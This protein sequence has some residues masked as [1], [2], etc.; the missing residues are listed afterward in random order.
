M[1][2]AL[3]LL[4]GMLCDEAFWRA[5]V[6]GLADLCTPRVMSYGLADSIGKMAEHVLGEAPALFAL[7]GH[8]MGGRVALEMVKRAP[9]RVLRLGLFCTDYRSHESDAARAEET[10]ARER[11]MA[12][13]S[14]HGMASLARLW[15]TGLIAPEQVGNQKLLDEM[16][17]MGATHSPEQFAAEVRA[18]LSREDQS[19][20]LAAIPCPVLVCAG[21]KDPLRPAGLHAEM[22]AQIPDARL[23]VIPGAGHMVAM[24]CPDA[25]TAAMRSWLAPGDARPH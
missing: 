5:Q 13:A 25:L 18:G 2:P 9:E 4:P 21:E 23:V 12:H 22:A 20:L 19:E 24:E 10:F 6:E 16:T 15:F 8:S 7:A 17:A 11:L 3:L 14:E 1:K